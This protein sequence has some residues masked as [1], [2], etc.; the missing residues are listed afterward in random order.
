MKFNKQ[1]NTEI[2][3]EAYEQHC[4]QFSNHKS[5]VIEKTIETYEEQ[6]AN[7]IKNI[8]I[9]LTKSKSDRADKLYELVNKFHEESFKLY[10]Q[11]TSGPIEWLLNQSV[12]RKKWEEKMEWFNKNADEETKKIMLYDSFGQYTRIMYEYY[13]M[14]ME[15]EIKQKMPVIKDILCE[16]EDKIKT[17]IFLEELFHEQPK[18]NIQ[19]SC[20]ISCVVACGMEENNTH[21]VMDTMYIDYIK[22]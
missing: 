5:D 18:N 7:V 22:N 8:Y 11:N 1:Y 15:N 17:P 14:E 4:D 9:K 6:V 16:V 3:D 13:P 12:N 21:G 10:Y 19:T 2:F 20:G